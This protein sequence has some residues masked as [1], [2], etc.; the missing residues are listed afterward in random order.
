[1]NREKVELESKLEED[2]EDLNEIVSK[3]KNTLQQL[4]TAQTTLA[5]LEI[6]NSQLQSTNASLKNEVKTIQ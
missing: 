5:E 1:L 4:T 6:T 2:Q 3:Q